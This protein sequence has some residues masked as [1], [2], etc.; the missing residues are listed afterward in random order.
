MRHCCANKHSSHV[1]RN[2]LFYLGSLSF[3]SS[4]CV[5]VFNLSFS[6]SCRYHL[7]RSLQRAGF[8]R[9]LVHRLAEACHCSS[10]TTLQPQTKVLD[11]RQV[12]LAHRLVLLSWLD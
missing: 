12:S 5:Y 1:R 8:E 9:L 10:L 2:T 4:E 6:F 7:L 3:C 11:L